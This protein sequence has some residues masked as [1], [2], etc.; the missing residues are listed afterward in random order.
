[1]TTVAKNN[2][3]LCKGNNS[4]TI[5]RLLKIQSKPIVKELMKIFEVDNIDDLAVKMML[6]YYKE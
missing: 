5:K 4:E 3:E 6:G 2:I 1:M